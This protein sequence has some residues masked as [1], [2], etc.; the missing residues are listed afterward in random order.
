MGSGSTPI[1][2]LDL[3]AMLSLSPMAMSGKT[4]QSMTD[5]EK[6]SALVEITLKLRQNNLRT[7]ARLKALESIVSESV[8]EADRTA[9]DDRLDKA[10]HV[11]FQKYLEEF[12]EQSPSFAALLDDRD[13]DELRG[14]D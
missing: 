7:L 8:P 1:C 10:T 4:P 9:W 12:E 11:I 14:L 5:S 13:E 6:I 3:S 2:F